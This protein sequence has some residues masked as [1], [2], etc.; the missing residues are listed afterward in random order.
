MTDNHMRPQCALD[1]QWS[2]DTPRRAAVAAVH[3]WAESG[4]MAL[5]GPENGPPLL[6]RRD[7]LLRV[8]LLCRTLARC[9]SQAGLPGRID[10]ESGL[11]TERAALMRF[12]RRGSVSPGGRSRILNTADGFAAATLSRQE[13]IDLLPAWIGSDDGD[14]PWESLKQA[15]RDVEAQALVDQGQLLSVP[16]ARLNDPYADATMPVR[17]YSMAIGQSASSDG[18][19]PLVLD[20]SSL[21][22]GPLCGHF[23]TQLGA[24]VI[25]IESLT[26]PD[27]ARRGNA[28][29]FDL[30]HCGQE[31]LAVDFASADQVSWL[32]DLILRA[33]FVIEGSRPRAFAHLGLAPEELFRE[34]PRLTWVSVTAYGRMGPRSNWVGFGD[35]VAAAA[36]LVEFDAQGQP[37]FVGDAIADP[38]TGVAAAIGGLTGHL[39]GGGCLVDAAMCNAAAFVAAGPE[40]DVA[41]CDARVEARGGTWAVA[42]SLGTVKV[43][44]PRARMSRGRAARLGEHSAALFSEFC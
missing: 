44:A 31:M 1:L 32:R 13:D 24:R 23:L 26:R 6:P 2:V 15:A 9:A 7:Y 29:F 40:V 39:A 8:D 36:G 22:A 43:R 34:N 18:H 37:C 33:D 41:E 42:S 5:T 16:V 14:D 21:W 3:D 27:S 20:F 28:T 10:A 25:K 35:D 11:L 12:A 19:I 4:L 38:V 30:L 17:L